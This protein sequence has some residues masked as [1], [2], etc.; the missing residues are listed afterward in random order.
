MPQFVADA[1]AGVLTGFTRLITGA[2]ARWLGCAPVPAQRIYFG[3]HASHADFVLIWS[4]LPPLLR[5]ITRPVA[6]SDYWEKGAVRRPDCVGH[7]GR[8][9]SHLEELRDE[10]GIVAIARWARRVGQ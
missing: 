6:G 10:R 9:A 5:R 8:S 1:V 3:N 7:K 2:Q 4:S